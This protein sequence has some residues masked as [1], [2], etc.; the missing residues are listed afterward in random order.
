MR[1]KP[2]LQKAETEWNRLYHSPLTG[3]KSR[4]NTGASSSAPAS[5][6]SRE[7]RSRK[8]VRRTMPPTWGA[9]M[10]CCIMFRWAR[11]MRR[12]QRRKKVTATVM[13][14]RPPIWIRSRMTS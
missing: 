2:A 5:S 1:S 8:P 10:D 6:T 9:E 4:M 7:P 13:T 11:L 14:P 3:P 12:P